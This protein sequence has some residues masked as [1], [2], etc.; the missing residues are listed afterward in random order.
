VKYRLL[1]NQITYTLDIGIKLYNIASLSIHY[2]VCDKLMNI[3]S[4]KYFLK[5]T[6][7]Y[8]T[9]KT[10]WYLAWRQ[11]GDKQSGKPLKHNEYLRC[12]KT[13]AT[14]GNAI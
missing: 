7:R 8:L 6:L 1:L 9:L 13:P 14:Y 11:R 12:S 10:N 4:T 2:Y 5:V 3:V